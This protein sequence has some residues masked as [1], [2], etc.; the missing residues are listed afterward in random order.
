MR[1]SN[2]LAA[3]AATLAL[4]AATLAAVALPASAYA[5]V[6]LPQLRVGLS[7]VAAGFENPLYVTNAG[8]ATGRLFV[9]EQGGLIRVVR[10]GVVQPG[11][12][13]DVSSDI[14]TGGE[15]GLLGLAFSPQYK[16]T[17]RFYIYYTNKGGDVIVE[18]CI[19]GDPAS[20]TPVISRRNILFIGQPYAN[21]NGG[22]IQ[23]GPDR[24]L[25]LGVGDGGS[26]GDPG[27]RAQRGSQLL[28]KMLR[29]D[30]GEREV[31][32]TYAGTYRIPASNPF[33]R[34]RGY[35]KEIW[36]RGLRN[37]WRFSFDPAKGD[38]WI[39]DVGQDKYEEIDFQRTSSK[40]GQNY[41][42]RVWEGRHRYTKRPKTVSRKGFTFPIAEYR[43][44]TGESVTGGYVY[45]GTQYP[46]LYGTYL[47]ADYVNGW[48]GGVRRY[49][50]SGRYLRTPQRAR[51]AST[52]KMISS[53]GLDENR[54]LYLC[55][56]Q[57]GV[58]Y[59]VTGTAK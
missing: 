15:R 26:G 33:Y 5:S 53:F 11:P 8:D 40:G 27:N 10:S 45:R 9:V 21:H 23:F 44:P 58:L 55:D 52:G 25:Y 16:D 13:L 7:T 37:P 57:G 3:G 48:I 22:C 29:I 39:G 51:L 20:D 47:Y 2:R 17:G 6:N 43:H 42:W 34:K 28:G 41:G 46:A 50:A 30:V 12:F 1:C 56:W 14:S 31:P 24:Y 59:Q 36:A 19:A 38:L 54:E 32:A 35:R 4:F 49:S 18:R